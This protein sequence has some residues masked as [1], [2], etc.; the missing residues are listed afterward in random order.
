M[1][2]WVLKCPNCNSDFA[3]SPIKEDTLAEFFF[4][5]KPPFP[6]GGKTL[7]CPNCGHTATYQQNEQIYRT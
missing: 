7:E 6:K 3:N 2:N 4:A 1:A 5:S